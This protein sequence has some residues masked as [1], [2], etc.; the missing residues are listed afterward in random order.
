AGVTSSVTRPYVAHSESGTPLVVPLSQTVYAIVALPEN[1][2]SGVYV[3]TPLP[4]VTVPWLSGVA[5]TAVTSSFCPASFAGPGLSLWTTAATGIGLGSVTPTA[6]SSATAAG[7]S[8][9]S[10]TSI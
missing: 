7:R 1:P 9:T 8:L 5:A 10:V 4:R 2:G 6:N 3:I